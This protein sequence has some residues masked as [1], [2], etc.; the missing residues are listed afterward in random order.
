[1]VNNPFNSK[2]V[3]S[4]HGRYLSNFGKFSPNGG[5][6]PVPFNGK[7]V[8]IKKTKCVESEFMQLSWIPDNALQCNFHEPQLQ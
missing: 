8:N 1:M 4:C 7:V 6:P 2:Y 3:F 5:P